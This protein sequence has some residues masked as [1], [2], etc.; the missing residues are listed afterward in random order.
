MCNVFVNETKENVNKKF[1]QLQEL[2]DTLSDT[3][4]FK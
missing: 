1:Q 4:S 2:L 3:N